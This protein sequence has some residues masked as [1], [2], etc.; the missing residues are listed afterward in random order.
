MFVLP[1]TVLPWKKNGALETYRFIN[2][3][4]VSYLHVF[5][6]SERANTTAVRDTKNVVPKHV[7]A[8]RSKMLHILSDKK[9]RA[10]YESQ[11]NKS[12]K[13]LWESEENHNEMYGFTD[14]YVKVKTTYNPQLAN[15]IKEVQ[16]ADIDIDGIVKVV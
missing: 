7:R 10:F 9:K 12:W 2:E 8:E 13:V 11:L 4:P 16:L 6:Y 15:T 1:H 5:T 14:N 3:L